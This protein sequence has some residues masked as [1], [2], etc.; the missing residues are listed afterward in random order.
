MFLSR[1]SITL[2]LPPLP[3]RF[4]PLPAII[5]AA[6]LTTLTFEAAL[7]LFGDDHEGLSFGFVFLLISIEGICGG[8]A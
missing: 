3:G 2:G 1:S 8:L 6:I 7:G 4:L 5:Q